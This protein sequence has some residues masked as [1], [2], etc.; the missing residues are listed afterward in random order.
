[1][2]TTHATSQKLIRWSKESDPSESHPLF[3]RTFR[4]PTNR[5]AV[6][7]GRLHAW[8]KPPAFS[9]NSIS[10]KVSGS[11]ELTGQPSCGDVSSARETIQPSKSCLAVL[12]SYVR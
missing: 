10:M 3:I 12:P 2:S 11:I 9:D 4:V 1:M 6:P 5:S 8:R 7:E